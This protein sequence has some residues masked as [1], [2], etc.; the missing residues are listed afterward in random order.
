MF[1]S[2]VELYQSRHILWLLVK[3]DLKLR[4]AGAFLGYAWSVL[5]PLLMAGVYWLVFTQ[6]FKARSIGEQPYILFLV[7]GL[8]AWNWFSGAVTESCSA[9]TAEAKMV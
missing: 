8:F 5:E 4:Y 1:S 9:L 2:L 3:R 7:S 6:I